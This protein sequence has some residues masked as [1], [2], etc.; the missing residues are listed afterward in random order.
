MAPGPRP[1][2]LAASGAERRGRGQRAAGAIPGGGPTRR[3]TRV[4]HN[5]L[6]VYLGSMPE[7]EPH[8]TYEYFSS[9]SVASV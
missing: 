6:P 9:C 1:L 2:G 3:R 8:R 4:G 5:P 7:D